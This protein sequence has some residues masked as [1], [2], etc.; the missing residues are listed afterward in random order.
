MMEPFKAPP[1]RWGESGKSHQEAIEYLRRLAEGILP[2]PGS[3]RVLVES[4]EHGAVRL[5]LATDASQRPFLIG[6]GGT[7]YNAMSTLIR[8]FSG[9]VGV[10]YVVVIAEEND[11]D[12]EQRQRTESSP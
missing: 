3:L 2:E 1:I 8:A 10:R 12:H 9:C 11:H 7:N 5:V 4:G 6:R